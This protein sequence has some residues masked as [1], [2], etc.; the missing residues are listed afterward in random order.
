MKK[1]HVTNIKYD[2]SDSAG[3]LSPEEGITL[4]KEMDIFCDSEEE[5]ADTI[6][7]LTGWLVESFN[8]E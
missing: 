7:D 3:K 8:I 6:S 5:I 2:L 1:F 4:P